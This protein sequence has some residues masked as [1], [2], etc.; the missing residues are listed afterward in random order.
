MGGACQ[1]IGEIG[2]YLGMGISNLVNLLNPDEIILA[3][4][5]TAGVDLLLPLLRKEVEGRVLKI[6]GRELAIKVTEFGNQVGAIGAATMV[7][8]DLFNFQEGE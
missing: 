8:Q 3:G 2:E 1:V 6:P 5:F 7:L 4:Y